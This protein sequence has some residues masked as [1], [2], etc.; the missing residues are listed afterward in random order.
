MRWP[1]ARGF[2]LP[3]I[4]YLSSRRTI[5]FSFDALVHRMYRT[6][7]PYTRGAEPFIECV[8][9]GPQCTFTR[10]TCL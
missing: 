1:I 7:L 2:L 6:G 10:P 5:C 8:V 9:C 3:R 4:G